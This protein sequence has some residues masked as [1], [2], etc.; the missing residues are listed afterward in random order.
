MLES[1]LEGEIKYSSEAVRRRE[2]RGRGNGE[3]NVCMWGR[4]GSGVGW[5]RRD[6][7]MV[8]RKSG[9]FQLMGV[10]R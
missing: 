8:V 3:E 4:S 6:G 7:Q 1:H 2:L 10:G 9:N 5:D